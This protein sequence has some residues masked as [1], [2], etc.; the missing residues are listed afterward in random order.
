MVV[1]VCPAT[2][3]PGRASSSDHRTVAE[4]PDVAAGVALGKGVLDAAGVEEDVEIK[5]FPATGV[6][7]WGSACAVS[8]CRMEISSWTSLLM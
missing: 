7:S 1:D 3:V 2:R 8:L 6:A 5:T 4:D